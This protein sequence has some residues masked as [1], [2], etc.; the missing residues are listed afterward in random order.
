MDFTGKVAVVLGASSG[1]GWTTAEMLAE[2]GAKVVVSAR[3]EERLKQLSDKAGVAWKRCDVANEDEVAALARY[4]V[5][6]YGPI[7]IAVN[8]VGMPLGGTIA[9][10]DSDVLRTEVA[11]NFLGNVWFIRHMAAAMNDGGSIILFSSMAATHPMLP[12]FGYACSKAG[13]DAMV[14]YAAME[15]GPRGIRVNSILPGAIRTEMAEGIFGNPEME[16]IFLKEVPLGRVAE[17]SDIADAVLWLAGPTAYI[18]GTNLDISGGN[19]LTRF[20]RNDEYAE[21]VGAELGHSTDRHL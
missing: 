12:F 5:D 20:P 15:Y 4:A 21:G 6:T 2:R 10:Q 7:D 18:T 19:Q 1:V 8:C 3:R 13:V 9:E 17:A 11:V 14:K 16:K